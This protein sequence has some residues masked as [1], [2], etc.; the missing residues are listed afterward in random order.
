MSLASLIRITLG[1]NTAMKLN[2]WRRLAIVL[3]SAWVVGVISFTTYE[4]LSHRDGFFVGLTLPIG[5]IVSGNRA[6]L[7]D[8][9]TVKLNIKLEGKDVKPWEIKWDN[10][11]EIPTE[12]IV[13]WG[14]LFSGVSIPLVLWFILEVLVLIGT[15]VARGF[16]E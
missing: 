11:P 2:G 4:A 16:R 8:G 15:W 7:P 14:K 6:I 13:H 1:S 9:R 5:T 3:S 10:E 12:T